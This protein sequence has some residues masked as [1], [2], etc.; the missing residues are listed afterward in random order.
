MSK[1]VKQRRRSAIL[2]FLCLLAFYGA[3]KAMEQA[4]SF[5]EKLGAVLVPVILLASGTYYA[6]KDRNTLARLV[7]MV[8]LALLVAGFVKGFGAAMR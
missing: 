3:A 6:F 7:S 4:Q 2:L 1:P 8:F 5:P